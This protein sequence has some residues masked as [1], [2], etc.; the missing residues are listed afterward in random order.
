MSANVNI[1]ETWSMEKK[2]NQQFRESIDVKKL[3]I[4]LNK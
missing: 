2:E 4:C 1:R 3:F